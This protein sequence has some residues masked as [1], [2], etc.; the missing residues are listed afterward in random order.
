MYVATV[1]LRFHSGSHESVLVDPGETRELWRLHTRSEVLAV[2]GFVKDLDLG[3]RQGRLDH[4]LQLA[5]VGHGAQPE[6]FSLSAPS[7]SSTRTNFTR[8]RPCGSPR[9]TSAW[10]IACQSSKLT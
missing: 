1:K 4:R 3:A 6:T 7:I 8:G 10:S 9:P 2:A 5:E